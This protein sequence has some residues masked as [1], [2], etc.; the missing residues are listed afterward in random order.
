MDLSRPGD[1]IARFG[2]DEF[3]MWLDGVTYNV[4]EARAQRLMKESLCM[5]ELSGSANQ[6]LGI[7]V[8]IAMFEPGLS[9]NLIDLIARADTAMYAIKKSG[10]S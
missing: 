5:R 6:P 10:K 2:G 7:S 8:G 1:V 9:E 4:V 3:A